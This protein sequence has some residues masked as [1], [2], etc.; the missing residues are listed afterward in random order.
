MATRTGIFEPG[1]GLKVRELIANI[2]TSYGNYV[3][4]CGMLRKEPD[5][6][7]RQEFTDKILAALKEQGYGR[8]V[9]CPDFKNN[10]AWICDNIN[11]CKQG[12]VFELIK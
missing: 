4:E 6:K 7:V 9:Q 12:R 1:G 10:C 2:L 11:A 8:M 3:R 5:E